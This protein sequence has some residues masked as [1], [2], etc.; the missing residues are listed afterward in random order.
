MNE[1]WALNIGH[2]L[3]ASL[4]LIEIAGYTLLYTGDY[5]MEDEWHLM[6][7]EIFKNIKPDVLI[8]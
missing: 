1:V 2:V 8:C 6:A 5:S 4:F 7:T 3:V